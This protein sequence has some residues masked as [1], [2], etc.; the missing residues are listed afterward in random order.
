SPKITY[1][2]LDENYIPDDIDL[3]KTDNRSKAEI[4]RLKMTERAKADS[5]L[6]EVLRDIP[7]RDI[8]PDE[9]TL[10]ICKLNPVTTDEDLRTIFSQFGPVAGCE[11]VKDYK[12]GDSLQYAFV[13]F[14][15]QSHCEMAFL[16]MNNVLLDDRR[17]KVDWSQ[18]VAK[19]WERFEREG[20]ANK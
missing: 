17:I 11:V 3:S 6:L 10:F 4:D 15:K 18:S 12:T 7:H 16:K 14:E 1:D 5:T 2:K 19:Q 20:L 8:R 13:E 9:N